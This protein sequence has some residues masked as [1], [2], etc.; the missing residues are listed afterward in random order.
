MMTLFCRMNQWARLLAAFLLGEGA[1][2]AAA[3]R[4]GHWPEPGFVPVA[5]RRPLP[6]RSCA[7]R[8]RWGRA[9][10]WPHVSCSLLQGQSDFLPVRK[11]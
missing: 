7:V 3:V 1:R 10:P 5:L 2:R 6:V 11:T 9:A 4:T 8:S